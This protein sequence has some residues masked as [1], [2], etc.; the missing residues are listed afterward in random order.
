MSFD[1]PPTPV[2]PLETRLNKFAMRLGLR[3]IK[4]R[5]ITT[6]NWVETVKLS[7][8]PIPSRD[9]FSENKERFEDSFQERCWKCTHLLER[10]G[11]GWYCPYCYRYRRVKLSILHWKRRGGGH[12]WGKYK[13]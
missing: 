6:Q 5:E 13:K 8:A 12:A 7:W 3:S 10:R 9:S 4:V 11:M 2:F 1:D